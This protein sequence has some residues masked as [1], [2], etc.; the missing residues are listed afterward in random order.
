MQPD[1]DRDA[2]IM[3]LLRNLS[4]SDHG[5]GMLRDTLFSSGHKLLPRVEFMAL[6]EVTDP[7]RLNAARTGVIG[8]VET[9]GLAF[10]TDKVIQLA[11][12]KIRYDDQGI[13]S[14]GELFDRLRDPGVPISEEITGITGITDEMVRGKTITDAEVA[15]FIG[16]SD[17]FVAHNASFDRKFL[18]EDFPE[19]GFQNMCFHCSMDQIDWAGRGRRKA[20]LEML[21]QDAGFVYDAHNAR[22]DIIA[23]AFVLE[24]PY[25]GKPTPFAEM[26]QAAA[27]APVQIIAIGAPFHK[28]E[29]LK[30]NGYRWN[31]DDDKTAAGGF[32]KVWHKTLPGDPESLGKE[33]VFLKSI[34]GRD[35]QFPCLIQ[36]PLVRYS[37]RPVPRALD[38]CTR[39]NASI[40]ERMEMNADAPCT[41]LGSQN[42]MGF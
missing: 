15:E 41:I 35:M 38:F 24:R 12:L 37:S 4:K 21:A 27:T 11:M 23:T 5:L 17:M 31:G 3:A 36:D 7:E 14:L 29:D 6:P 26:L 33:A 30:E 19:A 32:L 8:D 9:T 25:E 22:S 42:T 20:S 1:T 28:K 34:Y 39:E 18:E 40:W 2:K 13:I 16:D 10:G